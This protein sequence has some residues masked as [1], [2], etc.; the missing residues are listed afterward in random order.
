MRVKHL[1]LIVLFC[2]SALQ[3]VAQIELKNNTNYSTFSTREGSIAP[4]QEYVPRHGD[5]T[6]TSLFTG[7]MIYSIPIYTL[8][9][10][11]FNFDIILF[12]ST[13]GFKP[14]QTSGFY[15][16][17]WKL[18]AGGCI[19]RIE[20]G[21]SDDQKFLKYKDLEHV[22]DTTWGFT[23]AIQDGNIPDKELVFNMNSSVYDSCG[24]M[25]LPNHF[26]PCK[27]TKVDYLPDIFYFDFCGHK[28]RF[29]INNAGKARIISGDFVKIDIS[30]MQESN[31][32]N[33]DVTSFKPSDNSQI[34]IK[35]ID[36]Y[37]YV[38][39]GNSH[40]LEYTVLCKKD[41]RQYQ[42]S[43]S[44]SAWHL[45][46]II[47]PNGRA[48][49][50]N[51]SPGTEY[52]YF[53]NSLMSF[54]TDYDWCEPPIKTDS[55]HIVYSL[56]KECLLQSITT[57]DSTPLT[58]SFSSHQESHK[59]YEH[60]DF[61]YCHPQSQLD[62][63][64]VSYN[65]DIPKKVRFSYQYASHNT[66]MVGAQYDYYWRYLKQVDISGVGTYTMSYNYFDP[67]QD[68]INN[69]MHHLYWL[70]NIY[71]QTDS[72]YK[73][74]VDR[75]GFW[76]VSSLQGLLKIVSLPTGGKLKFTYGNHQ[77]GEERRFRVVNNQDVELF[78]TSVSNQFTGG[79][80]IEKIETFSDSAT[81]VETKTF[82]YNKQG[83][84]LS[85]GIFYNIYNMF[86]P[87]N[88]NEIRP[89][90]NPYNYGMID[91]HIGY[92]YIE[93]ETT[94]GTETY[95]TAYTFDTGPNSYSSVGNN[96]IN[97]NTNITDY[98]DTIE[99]CSGSLTY[100]SKLLVIGNIMAIE[101]YKGNSLSKSIL[102][103]Y[104]GIP[105]NNSGMLPNTEQSLGCTD[106]IVVLSKY[107]GHIARKLFIYPD[108]LEKNIIY[109]YEDGST[110]PLII[111]KTYTYDIKFRKKKETTTD[112]RNR[113]LFTRYTYPDNIN[114]PSGILPLTKLPALYFL[115]TQNQIN[116]PIEVVSGYKEGNIEYITKGLINL[117]K[118]GE[119]LELSSNPLQSSAELRSHPDTIE[120]YWP[121]LTVR[122]YPYLYQTMTLSLAS[123][124][125]LSNYQFMAS[126]STFITY[127]P[128][129]RLTCEYQFNNYYRPTYIK[130]YGKMPITYTWDGI[131]PTSKTTRNQTWT[132]TY[133]PYIGVSSVTDLRGITTY[134]TYDSAGRLIEEYQLINGV[135]QILNVYQY[136]N[137]TE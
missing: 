91:S 86:Y 121:S 70:P 81:L 76:K 129:Y 8:D 125:P 66:F 73:K 78:T 96:Y 123:P 131:Y 36:G 43:P 79:A 57:S 50:F 130:P 122:Y 24:V 80:R 112:S 44:V 6:Q 114:F 16:Q 62:S 39:G 32:S 132:F 106:T 97:K 21:L 90:V 47:A 25:M 98:N 135:K 37:T 120:P 38:F 42:N 93:Q 99:V 48:L 107:S 23:R 53:L 95:K 85:S 83:M 2:L 52:N 41:G 88:P 27:V 101:Q 119:Y 1:S 30:R 117:Y 54:C 103:E 77:Y 137:K 65:D 35:T 13:N 133:K 84:G 46:K 40:A 26:I 29:I 110:Q 116:M 67:Y 118:T 111:D 28:G 105:N 115:C 60:S 100:P 68:S 126:D 31:A 74:I 63:I 9:D 33:I 56:H 94:I 113:L 4:Y 72:I 75:F 82:L 109:D 104:N 108:V 18:S 14:F 12:Y 61:T 87:N 59:M 124:L 5:N 11:D 102:F 69:Y 127:D 136:H 34:T 49:N 45:C 20:Q 64:I 17:D 134:F 89:I 19:T 7:K 128:H 3:I 51:Y 15:G 71:P 92:S 22:L 55:T 10:P 58:I